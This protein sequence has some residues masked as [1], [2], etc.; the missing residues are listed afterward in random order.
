MKQQTFSRQ[1]GLAIYLVPGENRDSRQSRNGRLTLASPGEEQLV[2]VT[3]GWVGEDKVIVSNFDG[4]G[5]W[6]AHVSTLRD[7]DGTVKECKKR[8]KWRV[9][10]GKKK[11]KKKND[12]LD[13]RRKPDD[14]DDFFRF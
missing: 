7:L 11:K 4:I 8:Y 2:W 5:S 13:R 3:K 1:S 6:L 12:F 14:E 9:S 10:Y